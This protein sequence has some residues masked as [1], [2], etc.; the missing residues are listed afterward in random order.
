[1][2]SIVLATAAASLAL[3]ACTTSRETSHSG[4]RTEYVIECST[5]GPWRACYQKADKLC[6]DGYVSLSQSASEHRKNLSIRC[7]E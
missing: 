3:G 1:M 6:P 7:G 4:D 2:K 5:N